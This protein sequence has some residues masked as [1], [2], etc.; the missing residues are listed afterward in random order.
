MSNVNDGAF[1]V[2]AKKA[3]FILTL[4]LF[5]SLA[6]G[7]HTLAGSTPTTPSVFAVANRIDQLVPST[8]SCKLGRVTQLLLGDSVSVSGKINP[9]HVGAN[10]T[11]TYTMPNG[12]TLQRIVSISRSGSYR[13][14]YTPNVP[15]AWTVY[16]SWTGD[17]DH[18]PATSPT[19][20]FTISDLPPETSRITFFTDSSSNTVG[21]VIG[22]SGSIYPAL[23]AQVTIQ[24]STN[25]GSSWSTLATLMSNSD[26][27]YAS[28][29]TPD[30]P[31][32]YTLRASWQGDAEH[33][34]ATSDTVMVVVVSPPVSPL[35]A[36]RA[37]A[38]W[39][40]MVYMAADNNLG[41][42]LGGQQSDIWNLDQMRGVAS[43]SSVNVIVLWDT[44]G[45]EPPTS[46][47]NPTKILSMTHDCDVMTTCVVHDYGSNLDTGSP[48]T[49]TSF[50]TWTV[51]NYPAAHYLLDIWDHGGG[52]EG[53]AYDYTSG[54]N[55][56]MFTLKT[57]VADAG[58][59]FDVIGFD[60]CMMSMVEVIYQIRNWA[61]YAVASEETVPGDGW[62]YDKILTALKANPSMSASSLSSTIVSKYREYYQA[63]CLDCTMAVVVI[64]KLPRLANA[65]NAF[66]DAV[67][68]GYLGAYHSQIIDA[69]YHTDYYY[70][71]IYNDLYDFA[72]LIRQSSTIHDS[73]L[74]SS[75]DSIK[76]AVASA[77]ISEWHGSQHAKSHGLSVYIE[78]DSDYY[79]S[80]YDGLDISQQYLW[81]GFVRAFV[82]L[83]DFRISTSPSSV[84]LIPGHSTSVTVTLTL[85]SGTTAPVT[86]SADGPS[87]FTLTIAPPGSG[88]PTFSNT[89]TIAASSSTPLGSYQMS[90]TATDEPSRTTILTVGVAL[91]RIPLKVGWN[92]ISIPVIPDNNAIK[93][94]L[95]PLI[96][97]NEVS[98]VWSYTG[99]PRAWKS[100]A[101]PSTGSLTTMSDGDA[102]WIYMKAADT[103]F[104]N[105]TVIPPAAVPHTY[106]LVAG[107]NLVGFKP[108][109][110]ITNMTVGDYLLS[111]TGSYDTNSVWIYNNPDGLWTRANSSTLIH[112]GDAM[113]ILVTTP[114]TLRP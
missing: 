74:L 109:P 107:W 12:K 71:D 5:I 82:G 85:K 31:V 93:T 96:A 18:L 94:V 15:G 106:P 87:Y 62:P 57:A 4:Y 19:V 48:A 8:I 104:V 2:N 47:P 42:N 102:Y 113:W 78:Y 7:S 44:A 81:N 64:S 58:T 69:W 103:L 77:V 67:E 59:H 56:D 100:F 13:D 33:S 76:S 45:G 101:P 28:T 84:S 26:G 1:H 99:T 24:L 105:G 40:F 23:A 32:V 86:I 108:Q 52:F 91:L 50:I 46:S 110:T 6:L 10:V 114:A 65:V 51:S 11:L 88:S 49:L 22:I 72:R 73:A 111:I 90:V 66:S 9:I 60:A 75:A 21:S 98:I 80:D 43:S 53:V 95:S 54:N 37:T 63:G 61:D 25:N 34:G 17:S 83:F 79:Y 14:M 39:T 29:W 112:V 16:A 92:L 41:S 97:A 89:L 70:W 55:L 68:N 3:A 38:S 30:L 20:S 35:A 36:M 27:S